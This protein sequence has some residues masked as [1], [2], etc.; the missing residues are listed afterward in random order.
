MFS[1]HNEIKVEITDSWEILQ[2][3]GIEEHTSKAK[4][5]ISREIVKYFELDGNENTAY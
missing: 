4:E 2:I 1:D 5:E 3:L